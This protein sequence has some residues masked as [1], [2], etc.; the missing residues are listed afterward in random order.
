MQPRHL[1]AL[2]ALISVMMTKSLGWGVEGKEDMKMDFI[3]VRRAYFHADAVR[4]V[5]VELPEEEGEGKE[6]CGKLMKSMYGTRDA[7][8]GE[9]VCRVHAGSWFQVRNCIAMRVQA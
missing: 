6:V 5:Y 1:E 4:D 9:G 8:L 3:D 7:E 2:K